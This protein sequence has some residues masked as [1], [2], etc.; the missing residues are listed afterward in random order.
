MSGNLASKYGAPG[1][2]FQGHPLVCDLHQGPLGHRNNAFVSGINNVRS[3]LGM[4]RLYEVFGGPSNDIL[5][6]VVLTGGRFESNANW[7]SAAVTL[8]EKVEGCTAGLVVAVEP[9]VDVVDA[10]GGDFGI[11]AVVSW[12]RDVGGAA[13]VFGFVDVAVHFHLEVPG[14]H[15]QVPPSSPP[16]PVFP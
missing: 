5:K 3:T 11:A 16:S 15:S 8:N 4:R 10:C 12:N 7:T 9:V 2:W 6:S 14:F 13:G 1:R